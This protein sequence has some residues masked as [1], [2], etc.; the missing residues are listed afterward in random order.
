M[1]TRTLSHIAKHRSL[2]LW[3]V[4]ALATFVSPLI[5]AQP[6]Q[7]KIVYTPANVEC[8]T[9]QNCSGFSIDLDNDGVADFAISQS[10]QIT[11]QGSQCDFSGGVSVAGSQG[12]NGIASGAH[13]GWAAALKAG[14]RINS[15]L[16]FDTSALM[17]G[18]VATLRCPGELDRRNDGFS[19]YWRGFG[20][21][22]RYLGLAFQTQGQTHY[23]WAQMAVGVGL[24]RGSGEASSTLMG[25]A[26]ETVAGKSIRAGQTS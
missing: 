12:G 5:L 15:G 8:S 16:T 10:A 24:E 18:R 1:R 23:G 22:P 26:Y 13:S 9:R 19:G 17:V 11:G 2:A 20:S 25:Y 21:S 4:A 7:A 3:A 14:R 6:A